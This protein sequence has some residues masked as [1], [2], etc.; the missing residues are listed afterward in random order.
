MKLV[1]LKLKDPIF[2]RPPTQ[3][4][5]NE[6]LEFVDLVTFCI[7]GIL[8]KEDDEKIILGMVATTEDNV[9]IRD[10]EFPFYEDLKILRKADIIERR[11][12]RVGE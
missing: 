12:F 3:T 7:G 1:Y 11:D 4:F 2:W 9:K 8:V 10:L 5:Y 6:D